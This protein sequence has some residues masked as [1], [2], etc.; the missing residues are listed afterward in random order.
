VTPR[1]HWSG[2][3]VSDREVVMDTDRTRYGPL[4][5]RCQDASRRAIHGLVVSHRVMADI[6]ERPDA[7]AGGYR[8]ERQINDF[9]IEQGW[10][11]LHAFA[12][13]RN[14]VG[15]VSV[16][17]GGVLGFFFPPDPIDLPV[18]GQ[19]KQHIWIVARRW[20]CGSADMPS[21]CNSFRQHK[22][23]PM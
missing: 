11:I 21:I 2:S 16:L 1:S 23:C 18:Y 6:S 14:T 12:S 15:T 20:A 5:A 17:R 4:D 8:R 10:T 19:R 22:E 9:R 13:E 7:W 3:R